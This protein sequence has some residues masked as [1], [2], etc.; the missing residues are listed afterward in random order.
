MGIMICETHGRVG[1][2]E[3]CSHIVNEIDSN[4]VPSGHRLTIMGS[5]FVC[6]DCFNALSFERFASLADSAIEEIV[7]VADGRM[8]AFEAAYNSIPGRRCF[9]LSCL[10]EF[11]AQN[12]RAPF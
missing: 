1:F 12:V 10:G 4:S 11:E 6:D 2:V 8:E 5:L 3:I 7:A 9:C